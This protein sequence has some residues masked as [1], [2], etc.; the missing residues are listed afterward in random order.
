MEPGKIDRWLLSKGPRPNPNSS[1]HDL[2]TREQWIA[3][4]DEAL[5]LRTSRYVGLLMHFYKHSTSDE[6]FTIAERTALTTDELRSGSH[7]WKDDI[8][9]EIRTQWVA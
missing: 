2:L 7:R 6:Q 3:F 5:A 9:Y 1:Q 4:L 8:L